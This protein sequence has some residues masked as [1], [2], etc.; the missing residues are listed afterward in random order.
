MGFYM[1]I[2]KA[3]MMQIMQYEFQNNF[4]TELKTG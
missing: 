1:S 4:C 2:A 3:E